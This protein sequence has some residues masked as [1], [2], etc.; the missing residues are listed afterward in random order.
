[1][2]SIA[3]L[4]LYE[5]FANQ[6]MRCIRAILHDFS[7]KNQIDIKVDEFDVRLKLDVPDLNYDIYLSSGGPGNPLESEGSN[8][9][10]VYFDWLKKVESWNAAKTQLPKKFVFFIC[11]SFQ[12]ACRHYNIGN[13][14]ARKSTAFGVFPI[15]M[16][17]NALDEPV[18]QDLK[19]PFYA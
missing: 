14:C 11:H 1:M 3:I 7:K 18:F 15:H 2:I 4:D 5:G 6:G 13:V 16:L 12:L 10:T 17:E 19:D 8:W 9:E